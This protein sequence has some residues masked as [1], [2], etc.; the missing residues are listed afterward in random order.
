MVILKIEKL[1]AWLDL[2]GRNQ[3][4]LSESCGVSH[5]YISQVMNG[6]N[7]SGEIISDLL[8]VTN[9]EFEHLFTVNNNTITENHQR[10]NF[11]KFNNGRGR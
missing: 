3:A 2:T 8:R 11:K 6:C 5:G 10:N 9:F 1:Q 7:C 4:W